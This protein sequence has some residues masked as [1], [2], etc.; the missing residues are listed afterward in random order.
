MRLRTPGTH[1]QTLFE[2][3]HFLITYHQ[4][5]YWS[6][7][8]IYLKTPKGTA[9]LSACQAPRANTNSDPKVFKGSPEA[10]LRSRLK[11]FIQRRRYRIEQKQQLE[12]EL[13]LMQDAYQAI[14]GK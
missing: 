8:Y 9:Y 14:G 11:G 12:A 13:E 7:N 5:S 2:N 4:N 3:D 10:L 6:T 1:G